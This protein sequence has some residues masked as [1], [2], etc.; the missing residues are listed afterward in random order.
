MRHAALPDDPYRIG[1]TAE[2]RLC[3][4]YRLDETPLY[5][6]DRWSHHR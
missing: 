4:L 5:P 3:A 6:I 2:V 1:T